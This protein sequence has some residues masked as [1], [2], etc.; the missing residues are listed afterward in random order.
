ML[1]D[2][3]PQKEFMMKKRHIFLLLVVTLLYFFVNFQRTAV[4]GTIFNELQSD[5]NVNAGYVTALGSSFM[6]IYAFCQLLTG[7]VVKRYGGFRTILIGGFFFSLGSVLFPFSHA[8]WQ[9]YVLRAFAGLGASVVYLSMIDE[10]SRLYPQQFTKLFGLFTCTGYVG[11][12]AAG[13]PFVSALHYFPWRTLLAGIGLTIGA[14]YLAFSGTSLTCQHP[15][16]KK[17]SGSLKPILDF[18]RNPLNL[19][20]AAFSSTNWGLYYTLLTVI[21]KKY[22]EDYCQ[23]SVSA[24]TA[25][26]TIMGA[27]SAGHNCFVGF[28]APRLHNR[29]LPFYRCASTTALLCYIL[30][31]VALVFHFRH[32]LLA[33]L[34]LATTP[35]ASISPVQVA[36]TRE[37]NPT[38][39]SAPAVATLNFLSYLFVA[40]F[41][42]LC[43]VMLDAFAPS[44][45]EGIKVYGRNSYL[46]FFLFATLV[47][48]IGFISI[49]RLPESNG[50]NIYGTK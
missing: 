33:V 31:T 22:L 7:L 34:F 16:I 46:L 37:I 26:I 45:V 12:I 43:G 3:S 15:E 40:L 49:R 18:F 28:L 17:N 9:M 2:L 42:N 41:S 32:P 8:L 10:L 29:R 25:I 1:S 39:N 13:T 14:L 24:A 35:T 11:S 5:L 38:S 23:M 44:L 21:G 20:L 36:Y 47:S 48:T 6:Y 19:K 4:P 30:M 50:K 27:L